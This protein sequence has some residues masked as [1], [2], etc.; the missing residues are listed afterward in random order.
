M[1]CFCYPIQDAC[2]A[3]YLRYFL[4]SDILNKMLQGIS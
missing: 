1:I 4:M 3:S 2:V